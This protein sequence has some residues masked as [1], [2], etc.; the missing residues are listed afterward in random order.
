[1][2]WRHEQYHQQLHLWPFSCYQWEPCNYLHIQG[3]LI[4]R[5]TL[6]KEKQNKK[7]LPKIYFFLNFPTQKDTH[8]KKPIL[9]INNYK[10]HKLIKVPYSLIAFD[11]CKKL[12]SEYH[13][14]CGGI[15]Y[16]T[17]R[18]TIKTNK[19]NNAFFCHKVKQKSPKTTNYVEDV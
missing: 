6:Q 13:S 7:T 17:M 12:L 8:K 11:N 15:F 10:D 5:S 19:K 4:V 16:Y 9:Y 1:M 2:K 18:L 3:E 14:P